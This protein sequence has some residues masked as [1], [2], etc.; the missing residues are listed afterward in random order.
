MWVW[1]WWGGRFRGSSLWSP[2][3]GRR[4]CRSRV[5]G[6]KRGGL[7]L[8]IVVKSGNCGSSGSTS[9]ISVIVECGHLGSGSGH[10]QCPCPVS[11]RLWV[12]VPQVELIFL[13]FFLSFR[14]TH[15]SHISIC[16]AWDRV[17]ELRIN[18]NQMGELQMA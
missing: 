16:L 8:I 7:P 6:G 11:K 9:R 12:R 18:L 10:C 1:A 17:R 5:R 15:S 13:S 2:W 4:Y 3:F 14:L